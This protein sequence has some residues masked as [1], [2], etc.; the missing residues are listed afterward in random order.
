MASAGNIEI[1]RI[2][3]DKGANVNVPRKDGI[4]PLHLA[5]NQ[6]SV[7]I[8]KLLLDKGAKVD[9]K[10]GKNSITPLMLA[11]M[12]GHT[13]VVKLLLERGADPRLKSFGSTAFDYAKNDEIK[14]LLVKA[15]YIR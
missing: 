14:A 7:E 11:S 4:T 10:G 12:N 8:V 15:Y 6:G 5:S 9:V 1:V 3:L 2:L 13:E